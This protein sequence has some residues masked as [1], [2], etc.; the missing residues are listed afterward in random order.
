MNLVLV[1]VCE[2]RS[3]PHCSTWQRYVLVTVGEVVELGW[4]AYF[5]VVDL[6]E[7]VEPSDELSTRFSC[8]CER[9]GWVSEAGAGG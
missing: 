3:V 7:V 6:E 2:G 8:H 1:L 9:N 5:C 4:R